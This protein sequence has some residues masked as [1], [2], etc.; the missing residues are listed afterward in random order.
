MTN[1]EL[2]GEIECIKQAN[3]RLQTQLNKVCDERVEELDGRLW[4]LQEKEQAG[5]L[6]NDEHVATIQLQNDQIERLKGEKTDLEERIK[7][8]DEKVRDDIRRE[9]ED[10]VASTKYE[11]E[12]S[13]KKGGLV[14]EERDAFRE[15][16]EELGEVK[17]GDITIVFDDV[18]YTLKWPTRHIVIE[19]ACS[20]IGALKALLTILAD[21]ED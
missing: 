1:Q 21:R 19:G 7:A 14:T 2:Q 5:K 13:Y 10:E 8:R 6:Q 4:V 17:D 18:N 12:Q 15:A 20:E 11:L 9:F 3:L 16:F